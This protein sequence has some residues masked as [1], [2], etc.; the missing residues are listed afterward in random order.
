MPAP[1]SQEEAIAEA[2]RESQPGDVVAIHALDCKLRPHD[3]D[4]SRCTCVP[5]VVT[6]KGER[7]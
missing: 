1:K 2:L 3:I 4:D 5:L 6:V 7:A